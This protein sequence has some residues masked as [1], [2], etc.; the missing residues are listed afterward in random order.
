MANSG[1]IPNNNTLTAGGAGQNIAPT[2]ANPSLE[3]AGPFCQIATGISSP[4]AETIQSTIASLNSLQGAVDSI[5]YAPA[6]GLAELQR[7]ILS[8]EIL[9]NVT[10]QIQFSVGQILKNAATSLATSIVTSSVGQL[11]DKAIS[12]TSKAV[13]N[14]TSPITDLKNTVVDG[15]KGVSTQIEKATAQ[16]GAGVFK[17]A[18][19]PG[20]LITSAGGGVGGQVGGVLKTLGTDLNKTVGGLT[21]SITTSLNGLTKTATGVLKPLAS[22]QTLKGAVK[23]AVSTTIANQ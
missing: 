17:I 5:V 4:I 19:V 13:Q 15:V 12:Q 11:A 18:S 10:L 20:S 14:I 22:T 23:T 2:N 6:V 3:K 7:K 16:L 1:N 8:G 9:N 21:T